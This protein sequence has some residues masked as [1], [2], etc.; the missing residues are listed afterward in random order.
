MKKECSITG[1]NFLKR[2][3]AVERLTT[4]LLIY[5]LTC[6]SLSGTALAAEAGYDT[7]DLTVYIG[8]IEG[9][10]EAQVDCLDR[11]HPVNTCI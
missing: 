3:V 4:L 8:R 6:I 11:N 2:I 10:P 7:F 9:G 1:R 5:G